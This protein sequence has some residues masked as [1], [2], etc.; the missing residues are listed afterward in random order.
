MGAVLAENARSC[1]S[2]RLDNPELGMDKQSGSNIKA[3]LSQRMRNKR[4][5][6]SGSQGWRLLPLLQP[7]RHNPRLQKTGGVLVATVTVS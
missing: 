7:G 4:T 2:T 5:Q 3:A 6:P 1:R